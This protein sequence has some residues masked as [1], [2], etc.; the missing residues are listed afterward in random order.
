VQRNVCNAFEAVVVEGEVDY[1]IALKKFLV[2]AKEVERARS[3]F[4]N[5]Q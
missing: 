5:L 1:V 3:K 2:L 4:D